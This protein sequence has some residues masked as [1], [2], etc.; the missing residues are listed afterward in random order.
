MK[1]LLYEGRH[2]ERL[3]V[4]YSRDAWNF[5]ISELEC[6]DNSTI[7]QSKEM[8]LWVDGG[9]FEEG[10]ISVDDGGKI[11]TIELTEW[12]HLPKRAKF[13]NGYPYDGT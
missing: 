12:Q 10:Y 5:L 7:A 1:F 8:G 13:S 2:G 6:D 4:D 9:T 11:T 3:L